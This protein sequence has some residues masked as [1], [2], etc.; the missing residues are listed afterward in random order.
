VKLCAAIC[1]TIPPV[2]ASLQEV[3]ENINNKITV[4]IIRHAQIQPAC[5]ITVSVMA[6]YGRLP[7]MLLTHLALA[8]YQN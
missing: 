3:L 8:Q 4:S 7:E 1:A 5:A 2:M 6:V